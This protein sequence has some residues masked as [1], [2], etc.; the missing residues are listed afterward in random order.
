[1]LI[2]KHYNR[3]ILEAIQVEKIQGQ[4]IN[5]KTIMLFITKE[6]KEATANLDCKFIVI[7]FSFKIK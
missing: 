6:A 2:Q 5:E 3:S 1:M 7:L 4:D